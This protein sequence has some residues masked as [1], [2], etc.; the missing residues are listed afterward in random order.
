VELKISICIPQFNRINFLLKSLELIQSQTYSNI[1]VV[2]SDDAST[3]NT[4]EEISRLAENYKYPIVFSRNE[5]NEGYDRNYRKCIELA[6]GDYCIVIGN[7]DSIAGNN[8]VE[9]L[10]NFLKENNYP[11]IGFCN[12]VEER[13]GNTFIERAVQT[14]VLGTGP[15]IAIKHY[16]CFSFVGGLIYKRSIFIQFNTDKFDGSIYCQMYLGVLIIASGAILFS[17]KKPLVLKDL[18]LDGRIQ[19]SYRDTIAKTWKEFHLVDGGL[20]SVINVLINALIDS[21][22]FTQKRALYI[23]KRIYGITFPHW[24]LDYK[25]NGAF[26]E[27]VG[28]IFGLKPSK[29][30]NFT[31]LNLFNR[32]IVYSL[33]ISASMIGVFTPVAVFRKTKFKLYKYFKK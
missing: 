5:M 23:F 10:A 12:I 18:K 27:A 29:C 28:L 7:D 1:E 13:T 19:N 16:S 26:P 4:V 30:R 11:D 8:G 2:I 14:S 6:S 22:G 3:D 32:C 25:E 20:H 17:I 21:H 15:D 31:K 33:Y 24:I 9:F